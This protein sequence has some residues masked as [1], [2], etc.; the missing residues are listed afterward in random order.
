MKEK[1]MAKA[2]EHINRLLEKPELTNEEYHIIHERLREIRWAEE[3]AARNLGFEK[4]M[5]QIM[6]AAT[7]A[8][9]GGGMCAQ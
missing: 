6:A 9:G 1:L 8:T 5:N 7:M 3:E 4:R 2:N